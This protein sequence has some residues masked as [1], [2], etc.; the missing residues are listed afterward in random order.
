MNWCLSYIILCVPSESSLPQGIQAFGTR[1]ETWTEC[2]RLELSGGS[3]ST[4]LDRFLLEWL[5]MAHTSFL[6][7]REN[8]G[9]KNAVTGL[10]ELPGVEIY[11]TFSAVHLNSGYW[12]ELAP[13]S[14]RQCGF[15][16]L[17]D[18]PQSCRVSQSLLGSHMKLQ[19]AFQN[20]VHHF[21]ESFSWKAQTPYPYPFTVLNKK[22]NEGLSKI[23]FKWEML[24][25][26]LY[27]FAFTKSLIF[28]KA[29]KKVM[30][31]KKYILS[32]ILGID[33]IWLFNLYAY[34]LKTLCFHIWEK[35]STYI[36]WGACSKTA[37]NTHKNKGRYNCSLP[38]GNSHATPVSYSNYY[39][40]LAGTTDEFLNF[41]CV[42]DNFLV[43]VS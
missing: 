10:F 37:Q 19:T 8:S 6:F 29:L 36:T 41:R 32:R 21:F 2:K 18:V 13:N 12:S 30:C 43:T 34:N 25:K 7:E 14:W 15:T 33:L 24:W 42:F 23:F 16:I 17:T 31:S 27:L 9:S 35:I 4:I 20:A 39:P 3:K 28:S 40:V 1:F 11:P 26:S 5:N 22:S 38:S